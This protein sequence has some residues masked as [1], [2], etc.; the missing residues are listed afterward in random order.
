MKRAM[1]NCVAEWSFPSAREY[2]DPC[3]E[4]ELSAVVTDPDGK[5]TVVP[6]FWAGGSF[7]GIRYSSSTIGRH[8]LETTCSDETNADLHGRRELLEVTPYQGDN[9]LFR[10]GPLT[11]SP[12]RTHLRHRDGTP[13]FWL[14]DTWWMG[15]TKRLTWPAGFDTLTD[16][17][18]AKG[19]SAV[20]IVAGLYPDMFPFDPRG[21]NEA[22]FPWEEDYPRLNPAYFDLADRRIGR[23]VARGLLPCIVGA[24]GYFIEYAGEQVMKRHLRNLVARYGAW[25]VVWCVAGEAISPKNPDVRYRIYGG[26]DERFAAKAR[27]GWSNVARY[28]HAIDPYDH[29]VTIHAGFV[30][31]LADDPSIVDFELLP[32]SHSPVQSESVPATVSALAKAAARN[33][34]MP[35]LIGET[36]YEGI[37]GGNWEYQQRLMFWTSVLSGAAGHNYGASGVWEV[38]TR[39]QPYGHSPQLMD[40]RWADIPWEQAYGSPGQAYSAHPWE[41]SYRFAGSAQVGIGKALLERYEWWRFEPHPEWVEPHWS[42]AD[43]FDPYVAGIPGEVRIIYAPKGISSQRADQLTVK[44]LERG[45]A[46][47]GFFFDPRTGAEHNI[48]EIRPDGAGDWR[49]ADTIRGTPPIRQD[50]VVVIQS[51]SPEGVRAQSAPAA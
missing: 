12:D 2:G 7:W 41:D 44:G 22:G 19:F 11:V 1:Q 45:V 21:A 32:G 30:E 17:R 5:Q 46:Y 47:Q 6:A 26:D 42:E 39:A 20:L 16:D 31:E 37:L 36:N 33:P 49:L 23:L 29:P 48:G 10:H 18:V 35:A 3:N 40:E 34:R 50:W 15:L 28:L 43:Y 51:G 9:P 8:V 13:F 25:P 4:V 27:A 24:W 38:S 14:A